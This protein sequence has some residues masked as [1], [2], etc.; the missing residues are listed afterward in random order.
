MPPGDPEHHAQHV[1]RTAARSRVVGRGR[2][3]KR[4][5]AAA[6]AVAAVLL[7]AGTARGLIDVKFTPVHMVRASQSV[8]AGRLW[9][10]GEEWKFEPADTLKGDAP[11]PTVLN[12]AACDPSQAEDV[13]KLLAQN[14]PA[15]ALLFLGD[16]ASEK[17]AFLHAAGAWLALKAAGPGRWDVQGF[18]AKMTAVYSGGTDMLIRMSR[19]IVADPAAS[20]PASVG[21]SWT[22]EPSR[23]GQVAGDVAGMEAVEIGRDRRTHLFVAASAG[24]RLFRARPGDEAF[25]DVTAAARLDT[26]SRRFAWMDFDGDGQADLVSWDGAAVAVRL[27]GADGTFR[28]MPGA[29]LRPAAECLGL[30]PAGLPADGSPAVLVSTPAPPY[31]VYR[32]AKGEWRTA[33]LPDGDA[34]ARAGRASTPCVV[35]DLDNDG[36]YDVLQPREKGGVLWKGQAGG[37]AAPVASPVACAGEGGRAALGDFNQDGFLDVFLAAAA[38]HELW[39]NDG[40]GGFRAVS[41]WAGSLAYKVGEGLAGCR[42]ADLNHDGRPDLCLLYSRDNFTYHFNRGFR[43]FGAE[44][45]LALGGAPGAPAAAAAGQKACAV[46]DFNGDGSLDL[47]VAFSDGQVYCYYNDACNK[48][49]LR[50][51]LAKGAAGPVTVS[52]WQGER[53][54]VCVGA[55]AVHAAAPRACFCLPG[56]GEYTLRWRAAARPER[57]QKVRVP[58]RL[59][60]QGLEAFLAP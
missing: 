34:V 9:A 50:V 31:L 38:G 56:P 43:C 55:A 57:T 26:R 36:F 44:G 19:Y 18:D 27:L 60:A 41:P 53:L 51:G 54:P 15:P 3:L 48:P 10:A 13:R 22:K 45:G 35:A 59:P 29:A 4:A 46:A 58:D 11:P 12:L 40:H 7:A 23:L 5:V 49:L 37:F 2:T 25:D 28:P 1:R 42:V 24:D 32:D 21:A 6:W 20:V 47:A 17:R 30:A 52:L 16:R 39:E 33:A 8:A 14:G